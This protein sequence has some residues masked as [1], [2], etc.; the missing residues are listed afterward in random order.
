MPM[1][2]YTA[3]AWQRLRDSFDLKGKHDLQLDEIIV[4]V[5]VVADLAPG[6]QEINQQVSYHFDVPA[7]AVA[8]GKAVLFNGITEDSGRDIIIDRLVASSTA[9][10]VWE[11]RQTTNAPVTAI[12]GSTLTK[13]FLQLPQVGTPPGRMFADSG[14]ITGL[15]FFRLSNPGNNHYNQELGVRLGFQQGLSLQVVANNTNF[16]TTFFGR[17]VA[18]L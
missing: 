3:T 13:Q 14:A 8:N 5:V 7:S 18:R 6:E 16:H 2:I 17:V 15:E 1:R 4:P 11:L 12:G 10:V 9:T